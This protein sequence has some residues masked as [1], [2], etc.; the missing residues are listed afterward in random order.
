MQRV[1]RR[2]KINYYLDIAETVLERG[3]CL[4]RNFGAVIVK[5]DQIISSGYVGAPRGRINCC[6]TGA[7]YREEQNIPRGQR[8]ELCRSVHAEMNAIIHAARV[9][10]IGSTLYLV[11]KEKSSGEYIEDASPCAMC[12]RVIINAGISNVIMRDNKDIYR[13]ISVADEWV[14]CDVVSEI[15]GYARN[16]DKFESKESETSQT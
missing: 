15:L 9:D 7:C 13:N 2:D 1:K 11:G 12:R 16:K 10:M 6:D 5:N 8:F 14:H 3:T 4:R